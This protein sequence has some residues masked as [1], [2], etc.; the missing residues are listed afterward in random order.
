[1]AWTLAIWGVDIAG[2]KS[3]DPCAATGVPANGLQAAEQAVCIL[4][5]LNSEGDKKGSYKDLL[6]NLRDTLAYIQMQ[7]GEM[8]AALQTFQ[9]MG[10]DDPAALENSESTQFRYAIAQYTVAGNDQD[11]AAA[12]QRFTAAVKDNLYQPSHEVQTLRDYIF[13]VQEF[14]DVL[15]A[16]A[17][18]LWP[19]VHN[20]P[21]GQNQTGCPAAKSAGAK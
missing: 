2:P 10:K 4:T 7:R 6:S 17:N 20:Q 11:K 15:K 8:D 3:Q 16:S 21:E 19:V 18:R 13:P 14:V 12:I 9:Q 1:M 5:K